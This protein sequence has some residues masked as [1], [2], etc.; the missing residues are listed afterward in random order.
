MRIKLMIV[1]VLLLIGAYSVFWF[2]IA[3]RV[4][5][6]ALNWIEE[7]ESR[8]NGIKTFVNDIEVSGFPYRIVVE[9]STLN[10]IFPPGML[11]TEQ[12]SVMIPEVAVIFQPWKPNHAIIVTDYFDAVIGDLAEP[13]VDF[14]FDKV[15]SSMI[16]DPDSMELNNLSITADKISWNR[17][18]AVKSGDDSELEMTE[19]HLRRPVGEPQQQVSFDLPIN[20]AVFF[21][22]RSA[23]IKEL[24][25]II[26]GE[27]ADHIKLEA[28]LHAN[29]QPDYTREGL[30]K[31]RDDGGTLSIRAF[32]YGMAKTSII[33]S[34]DVTLDENFK[35]LGA[36]DTKVS[37]FE[38]L[39][40]AYSENENISD[41]TR[42]LLGAIS[43]NSTMVGELELPISMQNGQLY[44]GPIMLMELEPVID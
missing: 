15:K 13:V 16:F 30:S 19:F 8:V 1:S 26:L 11:G 24:S 10:A 33:L 23:T 36:F 35:P 17:S 6:T 31:W 28:F 34:G 43:Q 44:L 37:G 12:V 4:E 40:R 39:I 27:K 2:Q 22:A 21:K 5:E 20:R 41:M 38:N 18:G 9:A 29:E 7:S 32:E 3:G 25:S 42:M 14:S